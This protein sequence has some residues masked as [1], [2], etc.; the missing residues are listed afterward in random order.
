MNRH[1]SGFTSDSVTIS[2]ARAMKTEG[3]ES[4][5]SSTEMTHMVD[6]DSMTATSRQS[7]AAPLLRW[8][9]RRFYRFG[10]S[11][12]FPF[13]CAAS[14]MLTDDQDMPL[15]TGGRSILMLTLTWTIMKIFERR[16]ISPQNSISG[17]PLVS[18][19]SSRSTQSGLQR[20]SLTMAKVQ[21]SKQESM[22][23]SSVL[24]KAKIWI[25]PP[26]TDICLRLVHRARHKAVL[27]QALLSRLG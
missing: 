24:L 18:P 13:P 20:R 12:N 5:V 19:C 2:I 22:N 17:N 7:E 10:H 25:V 8:P 26:S 16:K 1:Q 21:N 6:L 27:S 11:I 15:T 4:A 9:S 3:G 23:R 14:S